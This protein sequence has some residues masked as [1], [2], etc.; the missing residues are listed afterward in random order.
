DNDN[1][2]LGYLATRHL[3]QENCQNIAY[4][5]GD[6]DQFFIADRL[7]G[8]KKALDEKNIAH[9]EENISNDFM[10]LH[11]DG[12]ELV[13]DN[14][15]FQTFDGIVIA[16][17]LVAMGIRQAL[18]ENEWSDIKTISFSSYKYQLYNL[19]PEEAYVNLNSHLLGSRAV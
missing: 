15:T 14:E 11:L 10:L 17:E 1:E 18:D 8:Y 5:G 9:T 2:T 16:D 19:T 3:I 13:K 6:M 7:A 12:Y 4:V